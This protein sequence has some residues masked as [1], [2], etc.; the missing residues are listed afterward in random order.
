MAIPSVGVPAQD[1]AGSVAEVEAIVT[2]ERLRRTRQ[3]GLPNSSTT[4]AAADH[5]T[6]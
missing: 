5:R 6:S 3:N 1:L 2:A 4:S